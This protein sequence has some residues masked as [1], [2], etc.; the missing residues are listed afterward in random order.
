MV[1]QNLS[2][3]WMDPMSIL[4]QTAPLKLV[5][6]VRV[7]KKIEL[8]CGASSKVLEKWRSRA[9]HPENFEENCAPVRIIHSEHFE[10]N[11]APVRSILKILNNIALQSASSKFHGSLVQ[12]CAPAQKILK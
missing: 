7:L 1:V 2:G 4:Y 8:P 9:E 5:V 6:F 11:R 3:Y 10:E 12:D